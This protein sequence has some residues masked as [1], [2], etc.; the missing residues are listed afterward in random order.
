MTIQ[1]ELRRFEDI[2]EMKTKF[3]AVLDGIKE[4]NSQR[5]F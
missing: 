2:A 3:Q 5:C 4:R 1:L